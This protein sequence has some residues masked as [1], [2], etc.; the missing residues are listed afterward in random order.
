MGRPLW[1]GRR[2][3]WRPPIPFSSRPPPG[4]KQGLA[5]GCTVGLL[6]PEAEQRAATMPLGSALNY[7]PGNAEMSGLGLSKIAI[8][9]CPILSWLSGVTEL[10]AGSQ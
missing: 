1:E 9:F 5:L 7:L 2:E 10:S 3:P 8:Y 6:S 4:W